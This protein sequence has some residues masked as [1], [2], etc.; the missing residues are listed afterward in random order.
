[1]AWYADSFEL[2][3]LWF[4]GSVY[5]ESRATGI[6]YDSGELVGPINIQL[7][8]LNPTVGEAGPKSE[9]KIPDP[10]VEAKIA[11]HR[12]TFGGELAVVSEKRNTGSAPDYKLASGLAYSLGIWANISIIELALAYTGGDALYDSVTTGAQITKEENDQMSALAAHI[13]AN[14]GDAHASIYYGM[15]TLTHSKKNGA[16]DKNDNPKNIDDVGTTMGIHIGYDYH[17]ATFI[18]EAVSTT[19]M[20]D[21][22]KVEIDTYFSIG[23][24]TSFSS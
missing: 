3:N 20:Y 8:L 2:A 11:Y 16:V 9:G 14:F 17:G 15:Q 12:D 1:M 19:R 5:G 4:A 21:G 6:S 13:K 23:A 7:G 18:G 10:S 22:E 24:S